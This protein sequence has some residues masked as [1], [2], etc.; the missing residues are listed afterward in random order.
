[1][2]VVVRCPGCRGASRV[3]PEAV[4]LLVVCPRCSDPFLAVEEAVPVAPPRPVARPVEPPPSRQPRQPRPPRPDRDDSPARPEPDPHDPFAVETGGL[5]LSVMIGLALL[6]FAIPLVWLIAPVVAGP[7]ALST[8]TP[9]ALAVAA[10]ALCLAVV[11]TVDWTPS[12]RLKGV[13]VLVGLAYLTGLSLYFVKKEMVDWVR[14]AVPG[15]G[16]AALVPFHQAREGY[17]VSLPG[18]PGPAAGRPLGDWPLAY[19][20]AARQGPDGGLT[21]VVGAGP[22]PAAVARLG[23]AAWFDEAE[24]VV[25]RQSNGRLDGPGQ[26]VNGTRP[27]REWRVRLPDKTVRT[28]RV[29]RDR[30]RGR[31]YY[32]SAEG[33]DPNNLAGPVFDS[34]VITN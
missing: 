26:P 10:A 3:G 23:D 7:P 24:A 20:Q 13:L 14:R 6:P 2:G 27:A 18:R 21:V 29:Y 4:G 1:M 9:A 11:F 28:V 30:D 32:L 8:A 34:F 5:P 15:P 22:V 33:A 31:A 17:R 16:G 19:V 25:L 12:T